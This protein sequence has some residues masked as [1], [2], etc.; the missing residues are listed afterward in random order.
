MPLTDIACKNAT[1][2]PERARLRLSDSAGLYLEVL[3]AGGKYWRLK[4]RHGGKEK[5]LAL[6][7]Y[8]RVTVKDARLA[9]DAARAALAQ[10]TDPGMVRKAT[11]L[12][13]RLST[14]RS[15]ESI[16]RSWWAQWSHAKSP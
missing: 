1:C 7:V 10:G 5:K 4:Y 11:K 2:P 14:E 16:A 8:P 3:P 12:Q 13:R 9:R 6:G 15:F